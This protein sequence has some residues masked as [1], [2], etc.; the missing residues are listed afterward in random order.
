M[1]PGLVTGIFANL[2]KLMHEHNCYAMCGY[3][4]R[5]HAVYGVKIIHVH[6]DLGFYPGEICLCERHEIKSTL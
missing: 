4:E 3:I 2:V 6:I 5:A 1:P